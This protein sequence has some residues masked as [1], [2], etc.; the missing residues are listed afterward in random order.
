[1]N[2][3][4]IFLLII[5]MGVCMISQVCAAD[6]TADI[7][8]D[9]GDEIL[10]EPVTYQ[11]NDDNY[12]FE[13]IKNTVESANDGD[14]IY[15]NG[16]FEFESEININK[17]ITIEGTGEGASF[18][19]QDMHASNY[20]FFKISS[21]ASKVV[22]KNI[23]FIQAT[24][25]N[26]GAILWQGN[27]G[28]IIDC[29]FSKNI[30]P[31]SRGGAVL[32]E[33]DNC[34][35]TNCIFTNNRAGQGAAIY[36]CG[37]DNSITN[38]KF[39]NNYVTDLTSA[40][41]GAIFSDCAN[42]KIEYCNFTGNHAASAGGALFIKNN[43]NRILQCIFKNN[44][45]DGLNST[46]GG[47]VFSSGESLLINYCNFTK[48]RASNSNGG[49]VILGKSNIVMYSLFADNSA[50]LG[51]DI[52]TNTTSY[53]ISN[54]FQI[55]YNETKYDAV[56]GISQS[57]LDN[58]GNN[59]TIF[60]EDSSISFSAGIIFEYGA[61]SDPILVT[62]EGGK[63]EKKNIKVLNHPE[64]KINFEKNTLT[65]SNLNVGK[66]VLRVT[67]TPDENHYS[68]ERDINITVNRATAVISA[69]STTTTVQL[70]KGTIWSI[71]V[72]N[73]KTH[74]PIADMVI[75]LKVFTGKK[76]KEIK[77]KTNS[78]GVAS[79]KTSSLA[80]G[81]HKIIV[82]GNH[83]GYNFNTITSYIKVIKPVSL[84]FKLNKRV[85]GKKGSLISFQVLNK[86]T[87]KGVNGV[88]VKFKIFT[89]KK[90]KTVTVKSKKVDKYKGIAGIFTNEYSVGKHTVKI[91]PVSI[92][93]DG[94]G[95][96]SITIKKSTK[97]YTSKTTVL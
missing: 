68:T 12:I 49:A 7:E 52:Y 23:K 20:R 95:K 42:L 73:S 53:V 44:Y 74:K 57:E 9:A 22:F 96:S 58:N 50:N 29:E 64:A 17:S 75:T 45:V 72:I 6:D 2:K 48:N 60:K 54:N 97:R 92:K 76:A 19:Q 87:K 71:K 24:N 15:L 89:G 65:V 5:L 10:A 21:D 93:Y 94:S 34:N 66:Y 35:I 25:T 51:K 38:C 80:K 85:N 67:T 1:M 56:Y 90:F 31:N 28:T 47:A 14:K 63:I 11:F 78:K 70:K 88:K 36:I 32:L 69:S 26:G 46:G 13:D 41:G 4:I 55:K 43:H 86:K 40:S 61:T 83:P 30:A 81:R 59:F 3:K 18:H 37:K 33:G 27:N 77:V 82:S 39:E 8:T 84:K 16:T 62:V 79:F 91:E